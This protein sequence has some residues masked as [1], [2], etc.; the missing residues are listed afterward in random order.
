MISMSKRSNLKEDMDNEH[1]ED[2]DIEEQP[3]EDFGLVENMDF[4]ETSSHLTSTTIAESE[5]SEKSIK[6]QSMENM[7]EERRP[8]STAKRRK[9]N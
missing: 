8:I 2:M 6:L 4:E 9:K 5:N 3:N 1:I 7:C